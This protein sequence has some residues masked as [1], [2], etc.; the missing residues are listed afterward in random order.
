ML[1]DRLCRP[2]AAGPRVGAARA[3]APAPDPVAR[4]SA[5]AAAREDDSGGDATATLMSQ[6]PDASAT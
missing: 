2:A 1:R 3:T 4:G 5:T 6:S